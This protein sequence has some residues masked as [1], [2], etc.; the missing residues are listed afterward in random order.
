MAVSGLMR[1]PAIGVAAFWRF[2]AEGVS[3]AKQ[4]Q[5]AAFWNLAAWRVE[6]RSFPAEPLS[7]I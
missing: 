6:M 2:G 3:P 7:N 5:D 4:R 1:S